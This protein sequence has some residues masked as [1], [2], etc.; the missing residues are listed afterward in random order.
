MDMTLQDTDIAKVRT[1]LLCLAGLSCLLYAVLAIAQ[2]VPQPIWWFVPMAMGALA[3][4]GIFVAFAMATPAAR[5]MAKDE[6]YV[7]TAHRAQRHAYWV[8]FGLYPIFAIAIFVFGLE[9]NTAFAAMGTLTGA[10]Y[11]LLL[12]YYEWQL[13]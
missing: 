3:G 10:A 8:L 4:V 11:L 5:R 6:M 7:E 13:S 1:V 12:M 2:N 9:W